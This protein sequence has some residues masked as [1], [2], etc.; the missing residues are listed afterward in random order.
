[1]KLEF[2]AAVLRAHGADLDIV[3]VR[4]DGPGE[5]DVLVRIA[6]TSLCHTD[7]EAQEGSLACPLPIVPGH[8]AAGV[9][10]WTG[11]A[12]SRVSVGE[13]VVLSWNPSCG[14]C[15]YCRQRQPILCQPYRDGAARALHFDGRPRLFLD[16]EPLHQLMYAGTFAEMAVVTEDCAVPVPRG[17]PLNRACLIG[18]GVMTGV[19]AALNVAKVQAGD[20]ASVIGCGAVGLSAIQGA[21]LAGA[22]TIAAIDRD[23]ARLGL[24]RAFG[25]THLLP[26]DE[27]LVERHAELTGGR[28]AD[29]V[30]EA[31]GNPAAFRASLEIVRPGGQVVWL[32]KMGAGQELG[33]RWGSLMGEKRIVRASY[34]GARPA[35][36]FPFLAQAYLDGRLLLDE[37]VTSHI[38]LADVNTGLAR[39]KRGQD[40]RSVIEFP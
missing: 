39:L 10:Q 26:A 21:R 2:K 40:V 29:H 19:G 30:F 38:A 25:A 33:L 37:Y 9:V 31:A 8:E 11:A 4:L 28:G 1:M 12:V 35:R 23:P 18:C 16:G 6:A 15:F 24:A 14:A 13:H 17:I 5:R 34:G 7:L 27:H 22:E 3:P 32:G 20:S 36:D